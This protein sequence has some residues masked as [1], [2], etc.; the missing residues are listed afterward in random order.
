MFSKEKVRGKPKK[1]IK[2]YVGTKNENIESEIEIQR[3]ENKSMKVIHRL[4][5]N[6]KGRWRKIDEHFK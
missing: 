2:F 1:E 3:E 6:L 5:K 4:W